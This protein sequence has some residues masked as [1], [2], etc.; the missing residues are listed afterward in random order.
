LN[1]QVNPLKAQNAKKVLRVVAGG[2]VHEKLP[3]LKSSLTSIM[4]SKEKNS[5]DKGISWR[6]K[7]S[8]KRPT[9]QQ[10]KGSYS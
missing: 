5:H 4:N 6:K 2:K 7:K 8:K 10:K 9:Q 1:A 3:Y